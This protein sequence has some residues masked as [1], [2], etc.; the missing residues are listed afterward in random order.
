M[1]CIKFPARDLAVRFVG[2]CARHGDKSSIIVC[3]PNE[4]AYLCKILGGTDRLLNFEN[5]EDVHHIQYRSD[6][7]RAQWFHIRAFVLG[8]TNL[9]LCRMLQQFPR[10]DALPICTDTVG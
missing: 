8:Y 6:K 2:K 3:D 4:A 1:T 5:A 7:V 9:V 10:E